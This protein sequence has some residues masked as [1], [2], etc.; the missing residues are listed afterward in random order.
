MAKKRDPFDKKSTDAL[1]VGIQIA[2]ERYAADVEFRAREMQ[3]ERTKE[4]GGLQEW[5]EVY[6][7]DFITDVQDAVDVLS[8]TPSWDAA[9][10]S[11]ERIPNDPGQALVF[12]ARQAVAEDL[13][14]RARKGT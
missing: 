9:A 6:A 12:L 13:R 10:K 1:Q 7:T 4:G 3:A 2:E 11:D 14:E 5:S 8:V